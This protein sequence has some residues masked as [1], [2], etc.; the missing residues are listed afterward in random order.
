MCLIVKL[1]RKTKHAKWEM[2]EFQKYA[3]A[4][5]CADLEGEPI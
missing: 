4:F 2:Y 1:V 3:L 5:I